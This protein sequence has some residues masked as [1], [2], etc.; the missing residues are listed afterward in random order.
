MTARTTN[1]HPKIESLWTDLRGVFRSPRSNSYDLWFHAGSPGWSYCLLRYARDLC[2][3]SA[4]RFNFWSSLKSL[5][6]DHASLGWTML[7]WAGSHTACSQ[8]PGDR[9][10]TLRQQSRSLTSHLA[11]P[12]RC[13]AKACQSVRKLCW[14]ISASLGQ[15]SIISAQMT[16]IIAELKH[17]SAVPQ[18]PQQLCSPANRLLGLVVLQPA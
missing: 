10:Q 4:C 7:R 18:Q 9:F 3:D 12:V 8:H 5:Q 16:A 6:Y 15:A 14:A 1:L 17:R 11:L 2:C 13:E